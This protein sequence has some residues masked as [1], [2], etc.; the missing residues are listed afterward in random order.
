[1]SFFPLQP[2]KGQHAV[3]FQHPFH[4]ENQSVSAFSKNFDFSTLTAEDAVAAACSQDVVLKK[5][6]GNQSTNVLTLTIA[7]NQQMNLD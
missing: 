7:K 6:I 1:M 5:V 2:R 4:P 3:W